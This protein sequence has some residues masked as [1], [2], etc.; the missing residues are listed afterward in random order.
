MSGNRDRA[1]GLNK[2]NP[3]TG[4]SAQTAEQFADKQIYQ[5]T[6]KRIEKLKEAEATRATVNGSQV[7]PIN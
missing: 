7:I 5:K 4:L 1:K 3:K 6:V 2:L